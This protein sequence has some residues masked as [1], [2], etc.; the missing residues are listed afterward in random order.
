MADNIQGIIDAAA[1]KT[2]AKLGVFYKNL[3]SGA[4][5]GVN[6]GEAFP[7]ASVYKVFTLAELLRQEGEGAFSFADRHALSVADK[8]EGSGLLALMA[9][10]LAPTLLDYAKLMMVISDNTAAD[11]LFKFVGRDAILENVIR[12]LGLSRTKCDLSC[13]DLIAVCYGLEPGLAYG[14]FEALYNAA[15]RPCLRNAPAYTGALERNDETSPADVSKLLELFYAGKWVDAD[16][17]ALALDIMKACQTNARIP[18][19]LPAGCSA[20]H[21][22]G[23]MLRVANDAGIVYTPRGAFI[24]SCFYNGNVASREE[25]D[26]N[27]RGWFGDELI[28]GLARDICAAY[29]AE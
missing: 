5:A 6:I 13:R 23:S 28:A 19:Y 4:T 14:E 18:K 24:L 20:A 15:G 12:P 25:Y 22:T 7:T 9:D 26:A 3:N 2:T 27:P 21:K 10:G 29:L 1:A 16:H 17:S 8:S 11:F